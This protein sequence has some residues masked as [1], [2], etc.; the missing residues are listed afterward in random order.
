MAQFKRSI[1]P[2]GFRPEEVSER[3]VTELQAYSNRIIGALKDERD[4]VLTNRNEIA[5]A[6]KQNAQI[7]AQQ[8]STNKDIQQQNVSS[9][10]KAQQD[11]SQRALDEYDTKTK[12]TKQFFDTVSTLS[13]T[14]SKKLR[15]IEVKKF[16]E[17]DKAI[18]AEIYTLGD[19]HPAVKALKALK[20]D[21][22]IEEVDAKTK[23]AQARER[24]VDTLSADEALKQL[25]ELGY[26]SKT[27]LLRHVGKGW[28]S[29]LREQTIAD[30]EY[31]DPS[32]G[33]RFRTADATQNQKL[34]LILAAQE[35][36]EYEKIHGIAGQLAALKQE[37]GYLDDIFKVSQ[38]WTDAVGKQQHETFV[39]KY[40][41]DYLFKL[42]TFKTP[43]E[44]TS[45]HEREWITLKSLLGPKAALEF[46]TESHKKID[47]QGNPVYNLEALNAA[48][49]GP[50]QE[51]FG[52]YWGKN[53]VVDIQTAQVQGRSA[54]N[55]ITEEEKK[56]NAVKDFR[57]IRKS[58]QAQLDAASPQDDLSIFAT[59][60]KQ[61]ADRN[62]G[63]VPEEFTELEAANLKQNK[64]EAENQKN[65]VLEKIRTGRAT[66]GDVLSIADPE[67]RAGV[68]KEYDKATKIRKFGEDYES[69]FKKIEAGAKQI[70][71][72]SLEGS[73]S[74]EAYR[75]S[76]VMQKNFANDY[77]Y[78][79]KVTKDP[80][81]A[82]QI[83][84]DQ[85]V[86]DIAEAKANTNR[87]ARY[88]SES[89]PNN[90]KV[91]TNVR[92]LQSKTNNQKVEADKKLNTA[93]KSQGINALT[94]PG[95]LGT[96]T[97]LRAISEANKNNQLLTFTPQILKA[98][99]LLG[100]TELEAVNQAIAAHNKISPNKIAP[101]KPDPN[102]QL[103]NNARPATRA[104]F[105]N[106]PTRQSVL[107]GAAEI[108]Q[109]P[110]RDPGNIRASVVQYVTGQPS[111][112]GVVRGADGQ[113]VIYDPKGHGGANY[114]NHYQFSSVAER[115]RI[116]KILAT[117]KDPWTGKPY[118]ITS[119]Q[120]GR[121]G[122]HG[123]GLSIDI[124]PPLTLPANQEDAWSAYLNKLLGYD[125]LR[126]N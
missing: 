32:T 87:G 86:K 56:L 27:A 111:M 62:D 92:G 98:A 104:L 28:A 50:N 120:E 112:K 126:A 53:R 55:R 117:T 9:Q 25:N 90:E 44:A 8:A 71:G 123:Q 6:L 5:N 20:Y 29:Y 105:T 59:A 100:I 75:L 83:A 23:V 119:V 91:F 1:Q 10:I 37:S 39:Q 96:E 13:L 72:D 93:I 88:F 7:E 69:T 33:Q 2:T 89:G 107:R 121:G 41:D 64:V 122:T 12:A 110:L 102:L 108:Q 103:V 42:G 19:N 95:L 26:T 51:Q 99:K 66:Q 18:A 82:L 125:P 4:A 14:A 35:H 65:I 85:L 30:K 22:Q 58:L 16:E 81:R 109:T 79:L 73:G 47:T 11:L 46:L 116:Q 94:Q 101:L 97:E 118:R 77:A 68:Q 67:L 40:M 45:F 52:V 70:M 17:K 84:S 57:A 38:T 78:A 21:S 63:I 36:S 106:L 60:R 34:A 114:H 24:G 74:F 115:K 76:L 54:I 43:A 31:V 113:A 15:E 80:A 124:A 48:K 61:L 49:L 3:N